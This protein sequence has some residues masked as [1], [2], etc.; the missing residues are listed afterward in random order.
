MLI[1]GL[2][3]PIFGA[4][5]V[6]LAVALL[7][8]VPTP[9]QPA[10]G[11]LHHHH[12]PAIIRER[13]ATS[14][15]STNWSGYAVTG[16]NGSATD[17]KGSWVVP[18]V[19]CAMTPN[20]DSDYWVGIDGYSSN[21]VEQIG[22]DSD[23]QNGSP[24]YYAWYEFYPKYPVTVKFPLTSPIQPGDV[25]S[26]E[27]S[28]SPKTGEFTVSITDVTTNESFSHTEKEPN[29]KRASAEWIVED[30]GGTLPNFG[31]V[32]FGQDNTGVSRTCDATVVSASGAIGSAAFA[33]SLFEIT[34][35]ESNGANITPSSL[36]DGTSFTETWALPA[37]PGP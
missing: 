27:V 18:S 4:P 7:F 15:T 23:C 24:T 12:N 11:Q 37:P 28:Y 10:R 8:R 21:T 5:V 22:T 34:L 19:N 32:A 3:L 9:A 1:S 16:A 20:A 35:D 17:V 33:S 6:I 2:R 31:T 14:A 26:A 30:S 25:I 29:A 36:S 13:H